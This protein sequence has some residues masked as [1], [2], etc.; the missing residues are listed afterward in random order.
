[1]ELLNIQMDL[2]AKRWWDTLSQQQFQPTSTRIPGE[3]WS[4]LLQGNK[5]ATFNRTI[6][7][8]HTQY[9]YSRWYWQQPSKLGPL[10]ETSYQLGNVRDNTQAMS[11][12]S[13]T[14]DYKMGYQLVTHL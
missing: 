14:L 1:M 2:E 11:L 8:H 13:T 9:Q 12:I 4:I 5:M 3:R 7:N 10:F 6:F